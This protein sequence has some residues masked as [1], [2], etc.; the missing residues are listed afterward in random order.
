MT[1]VIN[2]ETLAKFRA[3]VP[4]C[5]L[6]IWSDIRSGTVL[7][8]DGSLDYPQEYLD[9]FSALATDTLSLPAPPDAD[10]S[11]VLTF[12]TTGLQV[13]AKGAAMPD[14]A[15]TCLAPLDADVRQIECAAMSLVSSSGEK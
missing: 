11:C 14:V 15:L 2:S 13:F 9:A 5:S 4:A 8:V 10:G 1:P 6:A 12:S 7:A 3:Q